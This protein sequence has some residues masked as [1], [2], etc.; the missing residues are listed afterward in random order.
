LRDPAPRP[1]DEAPAAPLPI[2][3]AHPTPPA[4]DSLP[5]SPQDRPD[6]APGNEAAVV[7]PYPL[8]GPIA[9][10]ALPGDP[11]RIEPVTRLSRDDAYEPSS[12]PSRQAAGAAHDIPG[13]GHPQPRRAAI[14]DPA[15][16]PDPP[17]AAVPGDRSQIADPRPLNFAE[18]AAI[19][20]RWSPGHPN[21][22]G[23]PNRIERLLR[24][25]PDEIA[26]RDAELLAEGRRLA[27][28][29]PVLDES[30]STARALASMSRVIGGPD[31]QRTIPEL[32]AELGLTLDVDALVEVYN[33]ALRHDM[34]PDTAS[35]R[36]ALADVLRRLMAA[37]PYRWSGYRHHTLFS[38]L[39]ATPEQARTIGLM[40]GMMRDPLTSSQAKS[41]VRPVLER[42]GIPDAAHLLPV[43]QAAHRHG[44]FPRGTTGEAAFTAAMDDFWRA[45]PYLWNGILL[46]EEHGLTGLREPTARLTARLV[47]IAARPGD[48]VPALRRL[49]EDAGQGG[50]IDQFVRL[51]EEAQAAGADLARAPGPQELTGR[52][53]AHRARDPHLWDGLRIAAEYDLP[54]PGRDEARA[55]ARLAEITGSETPSRLWVFD[56]LRRLAGDAGLDHSVERLAHQAAEAQRNGLDLF[57]PVD[58]REVL[59]ALTSHGRSATGRLPDPPDLS[60][61]LHDL[62]APAVREARQAA[63]REHAEAQQT[64][65]EAHPPLRRA[66]SAFTGPDLQAVAEQERVASLRARAEAW[67]RWPEQSEVS[68]TRD[69]EAFR[70][71]YEQAAGRAA[72]GA[73]VIPYLLENATAGLAARDGGRGFG[74]ELEFDL[75]EHAARQA[76]AAIGRALHDAGL[77]RDAQVHNYHT[78]QDQGYR[79]GKD[80][81]LGLWKL[82]RDGTVAGEV[83][84]PILYDERATW[85]NLRVAV[86]IIRAHGGT[87]S[88]ATGGHV[89][90]STHDYDH[91][92]ANYTSVLRHAGQHI[93]T[94]FRL[95]HNPERDS[96]RGVKHAHP[97]PLPAPGYASIAP[98]RHL[99]SSHDFAVN[100]QGMKGTV[101]DHIEFRLWDGSL[102]PA[103]IQSQV[104]VSLALVEAAFRNAALGDLPNL[105][106][107]DPLGAHAA[108]L[109]LHPAAD[110][111]EWGSLSFRVLMDELFWRA[112][113]KDQLTAL[114][115]AT[116]WVRPG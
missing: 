83:V 54:L 8:S 79:T 38:L 41:F 2:G 108:L 42:H 47:E 81:G 1:Q 17:A 91:I 25:S 82:E 78:M 13:A 90:V 68:Y 85:E 71:A 26:G 112:A 94:L 9:P 99:H 115:A 44:H 7:L 23:R 87:A 102:D 111:T 86:E 58:R 113:D 14:G 5:A 31:P 67:Q 39:D 18:A 109:D 77:T 29:L 106:R 74:V 61:G 52:L 116:R 105:G 96:H 43:V 3:E 84:S 70:T 40:I 62:S 27:E 89:H 50:A 65:R 63:A 101:K 20:H 88:R 21:D 95:G 110:R 53:L 72:D 73:P 57:G 97:N 45:D 32:A 76:L 36:A 55:L 98:V 49:A 19:V 11:R 15:H 10:R 69:F 16:V 100:M 6:S 46:A 114:Y 28:Q 37:D 48:P 64:Y 33:D 104:K 59:D 35:D 75:P 12:G 56:P 4:A 107:H 24:G 34:S 92:L 93:D 51:A 60:P 103:V 66:L 80:G 30:D 22:P